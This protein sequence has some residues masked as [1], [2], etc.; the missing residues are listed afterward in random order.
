MSGISKKLM[1]AAGAGGGFT[2]IEDVFSTYLYTGNGSTQTITNDIDLAGEGGLVWTKSR[3][4]GNGHLLYDTERGAGSYLNSAATTESQFSANTLVSFNADGFTLGGDDS[5]NGTGRSSASWTFRKA[6]RFFDVVTYTG[7]GVNGR[8]VSHNLGATVGSI[9]VKQTSA[10]GE[11]WYVYHRS[12]GATKRIYLNSTGEAVVSDD[13]FFDIEPTSTE[14]TVAYNGTNK[15]GATYVAYLFAHDP[16]GPS[17]DG[18]DGLIACGSYTGNGT[19]DGPEI[20]LGW[21]PQWLMIKRTD[22]TS[23]WQIADNMRGMP[24][25]SDDEFLQA[26]SSLQE[27][28]LRFNGL[29]PTSTG[30]KIVSGVGQI[31]QFDGNFIYIAIRRGPMRAPESGTEVFAPVKRL[32]VSTDI[33]PTNT[34][35]ATDLVIHKPRITG[36]NPWFLASRLQGDDIALSSNSTA[37]EASYAAIIGDGFWKFDSNDGAYIGSGG[38]YNNSGNT[39]P[40]VSYSFLRAP[41][42]FDV[43]AYSGNGTAGRTVP[44]NLGVAPEMMIVKNRSGSS[45][46][47]VYHFGLNNSVVPEQ[48]Y[49]P[50]EST[51]PESQLILFN[52]TA[53]TS[54]DFT[55]HSSTS[56]NGSGSNYVAY[57]FSTLAGIS[58]VGF[59][60]GNGSSQT[61]NCGFTTGARFVLIRRYNSSG[62]DWY[63]WDTAQGIVT[64]DDPNL[65]LNTTAAVEPSNDSI[66]P[67]SS[68]FIVNQVAA[69]NINVSAARYIFYAVA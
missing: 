34:G 10:S 2:A 29:S 5:S 23:G 31:N 11:P 46:W 52:N 3:S 43:V 28:A 54:T 16:L 44:H 32:E 22:G 66:D 12:L 64:G 17:G 4:T 55:V 25:G 26:E 58:K 67:D 7:T 18:S 48:Y 1:S 57:L 68:G 19:T 6:P 13:G 30:F 36:S 61:I 63:V 33:M 41:S 35:F 24:V 65:S 15:S 47:I 49:L 21:E 51:S 56:V 14:F 42:F 39:S 38:Y 59:Y 45:S 62:G 8:T 9:F 53:P 50:L 60:T 40:N 69:N 27:A 37:A 20:D